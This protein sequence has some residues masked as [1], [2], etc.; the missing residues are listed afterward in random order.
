[1]HIKKWSPLKMKACNA[2]KNRIHAKIWKHIKNMKAYKKSKSTWRKC[3]YVKNWRYVRQVKKE[4]ACQASKK[5]GKKSKAHKKK[6]CKVI[7]KCSPL[8]QLEFTS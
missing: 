4:R 8:S 6:V 2:L 3:R 1:M 5:K 7:K